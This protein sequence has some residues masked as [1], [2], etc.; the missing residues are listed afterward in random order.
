MAAGPNALFNYLYN[1][2]VA[3]TKRPDVVSRTQQAIASET[4][5]AHSLDFF[6]R[7]IR[8]ADIVFDT[9]AY[10]QELDISCLPRLRA[11]NYA[12]KWD[13]AFNQYQQNPFLNPPQYQN[14]FLRG[15]NYNQQRTLGLFKIID[16]HDLFDHYGAEK[17]DVCYQAGATLMF[18][19]S[20]AVPMVKIGWYERPNL[21]VAGGFA[22]YDSWIARDWPYTI[23]YAAAAA[24][25]DGTGNNDQA[26]RYTRLPNPRIPGDTG[27]LVLS[28][29]HA[30][31]ISNIELEGR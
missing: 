15:Y 3:E 31:L 18:K 19:S 11:I 20:T 5:N 1:S 14:P 2:V 27:G 4:L 21:D 25:L 17:Y 30:L 10:I 16:P 8:T 12:R 7:D 29:H 13:P 9:P 26:A 6:Y 28:H 22:N 24:I 23:I